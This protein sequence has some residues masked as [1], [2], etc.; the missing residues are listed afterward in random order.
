MTDH[1]NWHEDI[2]RGVVA[3]FIQDAGFSA[4]VID[5][6]KPSHM[7]P[8]NAVIYGAVRDY[9]KKYGVMPTDSALY[10]SLRTVLGPKDAQ[11]LRPTIVTMYREIPDV[12]YIKTRVLEFINIRNLETSL[13]RASEYL[14]SGSYEEARGAILSFREVGP[15]RV[16]DYFDDSVLVEESEAIP[17]GILE[18]DHYLL[19][20]GLQRGRE[21]IILAG[22]GVGKSTLS[23]NFGAHGVRLGYRCLHIT[24]EDSRAAVKRRYDCRFAGRNI[25]YG[26]QLTEQD[27][28][29]I[30]S[31]KIN[32]GD[33]QIREVISGKFSPAS[34]RMAIQAEPRTPDLVIVDYLDVMRPDTRREDKRFEHEEIAVDLRGVAQEFM[35][36]MWINKQADRQSRHSE[37]VGSE[38]MAESYGPARIADVVLGLARPPAEKQRGRISV[39]LDKQRDGVDG[40]TIQCIDDRPRMLIRGVVTAEELQEEQATYRQSQQYQIRSEREVQ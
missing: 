2:E 9:Y 12:D 34:V 26:T 16:I 17:T 38:N 32:G 11:F 7:S 35:V 22:T 15:R 27:R 29:M 33:L 23:L 6:L 19:G 24:G 20:G 18:L 31:A 3:L 8:A 13:T 14:L 1:P 5:E 4:C 28:R 21:G 37:K 39:I 10:D 36:A 40:R 25:K 30:E